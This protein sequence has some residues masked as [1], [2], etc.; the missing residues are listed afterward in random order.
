MSPRRVR[1]ATLPLG[2]VFVVATLLALDVRDVEVP[3][4]PVVVGLGLLAVAGM[5]TARRG[6]LLALLSAAP[7]AALLGFGD[8]PGASWHGPAVAVTTLLVAPLATSADR[9]WE[10]RGS[11]PLW[12]GLA[13]VGLYLCVPDTEEARVLLVV[14]FAAAVASRLPVLR[15]FGAGGTGAAI[16]LFAWIAAFDA[17][18][19]P[20]SFIGA[21]GALGLVALEP[22]G[23]WIRRHRAPLL[24][25]SAAFFSLLVVQLVLDV[26]SSRVVGLG[27]SPG[28]A[29]L[30]LA[31][32]LVFGIAAG[33]IAGAG[34]ATRRGVRR[35]ER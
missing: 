19:R 33:G 13:C 16:G 17:R 28:R 6:A 35:A 12:Y 5:L 10:R 23:R 20:A 9:E 22:V 15:S 32:V 34:A 7:G 3:P 27:D 11:V 8:Y 26:Y 4:P 30:G 21:A 24:R 2:L 1:R 18:G 14:A 29:V 31:P 25:G